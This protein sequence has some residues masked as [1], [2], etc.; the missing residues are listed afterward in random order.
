LLH[1]PANAPSPSDFADP[2]SRC[3]AAATYALASRQRPGCMSGNPADR[4]LT[5][6]SHPNRRMRGRRRYDHIVELPPEAFDEAFSRPLVRPNAPGNTREE[7]LPPL[8]KVSTTGSA[9]RGQHE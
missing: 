1:D 7:P 6:G 9:V 2:S 5:A 8:G 4:I 3:T